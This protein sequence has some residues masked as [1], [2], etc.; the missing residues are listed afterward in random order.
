M[1]I[2]PAHVADLD[3]ERHRDHHLVRRG[4]L[5][6]L[7]IGLGV[8]DPEAEGADVMPRLA[9]VDHG[10]DARCARRAPSRPR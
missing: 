1:V 9:Q 3:V 10:A 5:D 2:G 7:R 4:E 6:E 8:V